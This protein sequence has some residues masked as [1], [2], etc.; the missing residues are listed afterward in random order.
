MSVRKSLASSDR[1]ISLID[2]KPYASLSRHPTAHGL[3]GDRYRDRY[4]LKRDYPMVAPGC[5]EPRSAAA[6]QHRFGRKPARAD[7]AAA[8]A[9]AKRVE[10][11][12]QKTKAPRRKRLGIGGAKAAAK[13]HLGGAKDV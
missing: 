13:E 11:I 2:G 4:E 3:T 5:R 12:E 10:D 7:E 9:K 1:I 8:P 6:K